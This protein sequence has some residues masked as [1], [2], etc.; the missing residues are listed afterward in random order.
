M[1]LLVVIR[2]GCGCVLLVCVAC[3]KICG[4]CTDFGC[5]FVVGC[6]SRCD[7]LGCLKMPVWCITVDLGCLVICLLFVHFVFWVFVFCLWVS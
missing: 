4:C 7:C 5:C 2:F 6:V 3:F 1:V